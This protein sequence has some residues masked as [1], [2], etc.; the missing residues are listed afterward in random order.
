M[1]LV[2]LKNCKYPIIGRRFG[3][4]GGKDL[5]I[6]NSKEQAIEEG[7]D[8]FTKLYAIEK[9][10]M[11]EIEGFALKSVRIAVGQQVVFYEVPIRTE[12]FGWNWQ[13]L[14]K[15]SFPL[16]WLNIAIR[17]LYVTGLPNG[18]VKVGILANE[19]L[20]ITDINVINK[21]VYIE[22][23]MKP[24]LPFTMGADIEF[25]LSCDDELLPANT[26]FPIEGPI[27]CDERQIE[28]DSGEY[29]LAE[30]RPEKAET[31]QELF[32][33]IK[34]L[35]I[36]ASE[37]APYQNIQ[38]RAGSMPFLG[39]QCGGHIHFGIPISLSLLRALDHFLAVPMALIENPRTAKL[40]RRTNHGGLGRFREKPYGFEYI[41]LSSYI[42][43][44]KLT[45][46][47]LCLARLI[48]AHH[49]E[50]KSDFLFDPFIQRAYY[51]GNQII[52]KELWGD[53]K[54][55]TNENDNLFTI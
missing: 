6:I 44:P 23:E 53:I 22:P 8:Y 35:I 2:D 18:F 40:R 11:L 55:K 41:S 1:E 17:A 25:M 3:H 37:L 15:D 42:L 12:P 13:E 20:I 36:E 27:G 34:K 30:I 52:L 54:N 45:M 32:N 7:F 10:Y 47:I 9:E 24:V 33:H 16:D 50:L 39:Y 49:H 43:D 14:E 28:Q 21:S 19:T 48:A 51:N 29:A 26:F 46:S 38:F 5:T 31:P 4:H